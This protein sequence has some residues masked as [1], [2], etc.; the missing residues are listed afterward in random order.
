MCS[1]NERDHGW[2][3]I[4]IIIIIVIIII[5]T[6]NHCSSDWQKLDHYAYQEPKRVLQRG[7][8]SSGFG[9]SVVVQPHKNI[10]SLRIPGLL[11]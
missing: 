10:V 8:K 7:P 11:Q 5:I 6:M 2:F 9:V 1:T 4:I 3:I